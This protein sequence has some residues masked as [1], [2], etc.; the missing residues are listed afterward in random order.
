MLGATLEE[1][2]DDGA[3]RVVV[4]SVPARG[5]ANDVEL[6][7]VAVPDD[8]AA[9]VSETPHDIGV[10][11]RGG[12][13]HGVGVVAHLAGVDVDAAPEQQVNDIEPTILRGVE[14]RFFGGARGFGCVVGHRTPDST[15]DA[16]SAPMLR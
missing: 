5:P 15:A 12:P 14:K 3:M 16:H 11:A 1:K 8:V 9:R 4:A 6:V 2:F 13:M 7:V 10:A